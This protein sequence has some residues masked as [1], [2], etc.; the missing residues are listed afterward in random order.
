MGVF[1]Q[2]L[3]K[4]H[5]D[6]VREIQAIADPKLLE[7]VR[8]KYIGRKGLVT[9]IL[10][11]IPQASDEERPQIGQLGNQVKNG[12]T[13]ALEAKERAFQDRAPAGSAIFDYT[14]PGRG[15]WPGKKH[16]LT[17]VI[18]EIKDIFYGIG[19]SLVAGPDIETD[20]YNFEALNFPDDHPARDM[21]DTFGLGGE[22]V[23]RTQTSSVQV[24]V[25]EK[26]RPPVRVI[27]PGRCYRCDEQDATHSP[28]FHQVEGLYVDKHVTFAQLKGTLLT[29]AQKMFGKDIKIRFRTGFFPFTEPSAEYDLSCV[30][31][32]GKGCRVCKGTGWLEISGAGMVDPGVFKFVDYDPE[33]Y[34]GFA[35]GMGIERIAM[36]KYVSTISVFFSRTMCGSLTSFKKHENF[37]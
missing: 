22:Y 6:A 32:K 30:I 31:C 12:I 4:I 37:V 23:L 36:I 14:L 1:L 11:D 20:Y 21:Q 8:V 35:F 27:S 5:Q 17:L 13:Q 34:S 33:I 18:D 25:M 2:E 15:L 29:F 28:M 3:G 10:R 16:P 19:F 9:K 24:R 26:Q 7:E